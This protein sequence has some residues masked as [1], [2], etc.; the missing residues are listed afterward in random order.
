M[1]TKLAAQLLAELKASGDPRVIGGAQAFDEYP[2][3]GGVPTYPGVE[4]LDAY[5]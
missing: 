1:K 3:Y 4:A 5:R 2:Y